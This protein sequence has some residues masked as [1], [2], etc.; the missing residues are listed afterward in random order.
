MEEFGWRTREKWRERDDRLGGY[1]VK[2][3]M[4][5]FGWKDEAI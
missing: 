5:E 3:G 1:L 2:F 4:E